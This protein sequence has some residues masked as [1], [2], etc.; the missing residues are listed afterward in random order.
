MYTKEVLLEQ[1]FLRVVGGV[2]N[3]DSSVER[4]DIGPYLNAAIRWFHKKHYYELRR[5]EGFGFDEDSLA[6][7]SIE[8]DTKIREFDVAV[9]PVNPLVLP[10]GFAIDTVMPAEGMVP[11]VRVRGQQWL[12][13]LSRAID[14]VFWWPEGRNIFLY[15]LG[16]VCSIHVRAIPDPGSLG[17]TDTVLLPAGGDV[18]VVN[19]AVEFFTGQRQ[20]PKDLIIDNSDKPTP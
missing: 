13:G 15:N 2:T 19:V 14:T 17:D 8:A 12:L 20:M 4:V 1:I 16:K 18:E 6:T 7:Y 3:K 5:E 9:L 11:F 10:G